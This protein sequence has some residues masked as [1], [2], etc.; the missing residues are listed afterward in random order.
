VRSLVFWLTIML[1]FALSGLRS[2]LRGRSF[3]AVFVL[4]VLLI[5]VAYLSGR[6]V[7]MSITWADMGVTPCWANGPG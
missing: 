3:Q 2:G 1:E 4:G 7:R 6:W 5:G